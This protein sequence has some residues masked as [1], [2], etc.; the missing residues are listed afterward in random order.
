M[1]EQV[2]EAEVKEQPKVSDAEHE[3]RNLGWVDKEEFKGDPAKWRPAEEFLDRGKRILP[4]VLK[5]NERLQ[6]NLDRVKDQLA[7][8]REQTKQLVEFHTKAEERAYERARKEVEA[9]I[10]SA[11]ANADQAAVRHEMA[12]LDALNKQH[13]EPVKK[14]PPTPQ[15]DPVIRDWI[16]REEWFQKDRMLNA[17]AVDVYGVLERDKPGLSKADLLAET[18]R[19]TVEK[20]PEKFAVEDRPKSAAVATPSAGAPRKRG[21]VYEDLP[22]EAKAACD[23]FVKSIPN[24]TREKY[25]KDYDWEG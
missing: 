20:F 8:V 23:K 16:D 3:A 14:A 6:R 21:K 13:I 2:E 12:N 11:A 4:I 25:V 10:E 22:A 15:F 24:Y 19:R 9:K 5:D 1:S 18:K 17:Y 7:E